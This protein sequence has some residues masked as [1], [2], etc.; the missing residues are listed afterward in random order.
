MKKALRIGYNRYYSDE[1]FAEHIKFIKKN[2]DVIDEITMF[3]EF[4]HYGYWPL[5]YSK[6]HAQLMK[7]R[8]EEYRNAGVKKVGINLLCTL[9]HLEEAWDIFER[10][11]LQYMVNENGVESKACLCMLGDDFLEYIKNRY[12]IY[13]D[14]GADFIWIDDDLRI[15]N[16]GVAQTGCYCDK[17][18]SSFNE[19]NGTSYD[20][21]GLVN[22]INNDKSVKKA[23]DEFGNAKSIRLCEVIKDAIISTNPSTGI[24]LMTCEAMAKK[25]FTDAIGATMC[26]PGGGAYTD[27][28]PTE[29]F[30]KSCSIALQSENY[31]DHI[32]DI[33]YEYEAFNYQKLERSVHMSELETSLMLMSGCNGV[34][35]NN[36][37]F[38]DRQ[39]MCDMLKDSQKKWSELVRINKGCKNA[40]VYYTNSVVAFYLNEVGIPTTPTIENA[41][42]AIVLGDDLSSLSD[43]EIAK[44]LKLN[45]L[46]DGKGVEILTRRG[47]GDVCGAKIKKSYTNGMAQRFT[48]HSINGEF[49]NY[50]RDTFMNFYY[51]GDAYEFEL[52]ES[53]ET[54]ALLEK[55]THSPVGIS[56]YIYENDGAKFAADG[57]LMLGQHKSPA[58]KM[59]LTNIFE[60]LSDNKL[61]IKIDAELKIIPKV[62]TDKNGNMNI[63]L[64]NASFDK[65]GAFECEIRGEGPFSILGDDG[66]YASAKQT[67][68]GGVTRVL[69]DNL[70][71]WDYILLTNNNL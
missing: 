69:I 61:P 45:I 3:V 11:D 21:D 47:F 49:K 15:G 62:T 54:I 10:A 39:D 44:I 17:C 70:D 67:S 25:E 7:K 53:A 29:Y 64:S 66:K 51:E 23:W 71:A 60:W 26:R 42:S 27:T 41:S 38:D 56:T 55:T 40:G 8:I 18:I 35:Y 52:S 58:K 48:E 63:M 65:T 36:F 37:F 5:D 46:T 59:Q 34:L 20:R 9:G 30:L 4:S 14:I 2:I 19:K 57:F 12:A 16:H 1:V 33:Q 28:A 22:A 24:G 32:D 13:S 68:S 43:E 31:P 6:K 50:Y